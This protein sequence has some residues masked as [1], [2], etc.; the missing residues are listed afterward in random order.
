MAVSQAQVSPDTTHWIVNNE[1]AAWRDDGPESDAMPASLMGGSG[2]SAFGLSILR[3]RCR[4]EAQHPKSSAIH[5]L[6]RPI[7]PSFV[8]I[9]PNPPVARAMSAGGCAP[10]LSA[11]DNAAI[12]YHTA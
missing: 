1:R 5:R 10:L 9:A 7:T 4:S 12:L 2:S 11:G 6:G 3:C 8:R